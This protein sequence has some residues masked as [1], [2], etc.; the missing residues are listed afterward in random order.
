MPDAPVKAFFAG[1]CDCHMHVYDSRFPLVPNLAVTPPDAP[2]FRYLPVQRALGL[3]RVVVVQPM[4]YSFDNRCTLDAMGQFGQIARGICII[5]SD[6]GDAEIERLH[7]LGVRGVRYMMLG[8]PLGWDSLEPV[9]ARLKDFGWMINL[10]LDG[11]NLPAHEEVLMRLPCTLVIDHNGKFLE[12]VAI[13]SPAFQALV[14]LLEKGNSWVKLS[15]PYETSKTGAPSY[16]DVSAIARELVRRFPDRCLWASNWPHPGRNP[17][18]SD[19]ALYELL[20]TWAPDAAVRRK[21]LVDNP[22]RLYGFKS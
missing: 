5:P 6:T 14:R 2:A 9:A 8:G 18:P 12:P 17:P 11:R 1:A 19:A 13:D 16:D 10:Q 21:I 20:A 7:A 3:E 15:A 4:G 22:A